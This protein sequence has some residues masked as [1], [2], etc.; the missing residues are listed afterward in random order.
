L[1]EVPAI[2]SF[3]CALVAQITVSSHG[4]YYSEATV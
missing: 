1:D 4:C 2:R 3:L